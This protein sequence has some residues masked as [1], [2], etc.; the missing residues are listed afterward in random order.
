[1]KAVLLLCFACVLPVSSQTGTAKLQTGSRVPA[2]SIHFDEQSAGK[3]KF[4]IRN[5][6]GHAVTALDILFVPV[7][8]AR[9]GNHYSCR[10]RCSNR[11]GIA[12]AERPLLPAGVSLQ[13]TY[14]ESDI[15]TAVIIE[16][17]V[18][19]DASYAGGERAAAAMVATQLGNQAEFDRITSAVETVMTDPI[20]QNGNSGGQL[21]SALAAV[22]T[23]PDSA[24]MEAFYRW[25]PNIRDCSRLFPEI[26]QN[27]SSKV[28]ADVQGTL[29]PLFSSGSPTPSAVETWWKSTQQYL[30]GFGCKECA[31][32]LASPTPPVQIRTVSIGCRASTS[33][34][35]A[36][37][38]TQL[39]SEDDSGADDDSSGDGSAQTADSNSGAT[40]D[41]SLTMTEEPNAPVGADATPTV[42]TAG[43]TTPPAMS[44]ANPILP[45]LSSAR[46]ESRCLPMTP[47][48]LPALRSR[49]SQ[50]DNPLRPVLD[51][52][53][54]PR[55]FRYVSEWEKCLGD[56]QWPD[57]T[58]ARYPDPY[59]SAL[60]EDQREIVRV[61]ATDWLETEG[62]GLG[63]HPVGAGI[64]MVPPVRAETW[65]QAQ[66]GLQRRQQ[67]EQEREERAKAVAARVQSLRLALGKKSFPVLDAYAHDLYQTV[68][69]RAVR[70]PL[71]DRA[72]LSRY[73]HYIALMDKFASN[74]GDDGRAAAKARA[75]EQTACGL[76]ADDQRVLQQEA[77]SWR[78]SI[79]SRRPPA[80]GEGMAASRT[81][82]PRSGDG[83]GPA[84]DAN[85][86]P[87]RLMEKL[88]ARLSKASFEKVQKRMHALYDSEGM[89]RVVPADEPEPTP[90]M[91]QKMPAK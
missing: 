2:V 68:P 17:A 65:A 49:D 38:D 37:A 20:V 61:I 76:N 90:T 8:V 7:G 85:D 88:Q 42:N 53:L 28:K 32:K 64:P 6:S 24:Q 5:G 69:G 91:T 55:Y 86:R 59:P 47:R 19:D 58:I 70:E 11:A 45:Q 22:A 1:M 83:A 50:E 41:D 80:R 39:L 26:M 82:P 29:Q 15:G 78:S 23:E 31:T 25:F 48:P 73:L 62:P 21:D 67:M 4:T 77:D 13:A 57:E 72:M 84:E 16:A 60:N 51:E 3:Y 27:A 18:F 79:E 33:G 43:S 14:D 46:A 56:G 71:S 87:Q 10:G 74:Q 9:H 89:N 81:A 75:D 63:L 40:G 34:Q 36:S 35:T 12:N 54:Y 44:R 52:F 30:T 66:Q